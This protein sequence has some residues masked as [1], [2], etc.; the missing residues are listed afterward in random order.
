MS[1]GRKVN[2][3]EKKWRVRG[4]AQSAATISNLQDRTGDLLL[5]FWLEPTHRRAGDPELGK[6]SR[7]KGRNAVAATRTAAT[8]HS[9]A[10]LAL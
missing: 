10:D 1:S 9:R 3:V 8:F 7:S 5:L 4:S 2:G 6:A